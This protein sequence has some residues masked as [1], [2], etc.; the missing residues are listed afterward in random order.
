MM[1]GYLRA[2]ST[3]MLPESNPPLRATPT[4]TSERI[5]SSLTVSNSARSSSP[6]GPFSAGASS[7]FQ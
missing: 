5:T 4:G 3:A 6:G 2:A 7:M 1:P